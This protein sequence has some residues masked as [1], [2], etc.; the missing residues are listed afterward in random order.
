[1]GFAEREE[2]EAALQ[3][4]MIDLSEKRIKLAHAVRLRH[5]GMCDLLG[6]QHCRR[7]DQNSNPTYPLNR[8]SSLTT[9][10][11]TRPSSLT[12]YRSTPV[13]TM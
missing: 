7:T 13:L 8:P 11:L 3:Q 2:K 9:Y 4:A 12:T 5:K 1:M 6:C 10:L